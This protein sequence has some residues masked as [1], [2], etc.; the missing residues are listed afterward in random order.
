MKVLPRSFKM[1]LETW[2]GAV[3]LGRLRFPS[4]PEVVLFPWREAFPAK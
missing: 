1:E 3:G 4:G 2:T